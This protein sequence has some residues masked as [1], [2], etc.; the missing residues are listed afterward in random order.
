[1]INLLG[2]RS[3]LS[4]NSEDFTNETELPYRFSVFNVLTLNLKNLFSHVSVP[5]KLIMGSS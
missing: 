5:K 1:M 3:E 4:R 2:R